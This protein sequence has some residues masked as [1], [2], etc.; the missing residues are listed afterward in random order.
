MNEKNENVMVCADC[1][2]KKIC[3][4]EQAIISAMKNLSDYYPHI[5]WK[6]TCDYRDSVKVED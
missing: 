2:L 6:T 5:H 1:P 3:C 4:H